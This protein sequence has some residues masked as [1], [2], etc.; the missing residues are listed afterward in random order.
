MPDPP[1]LFDGHVWPMYQ[2]HT[3]IMEE[4]GVDVC[5]YDLFKMYSSFGALVTFRCDLYYDFL[6]YSAAR[7]NHD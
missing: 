4:S 1:G 3:R 7:W 2:K 5:K 6:F